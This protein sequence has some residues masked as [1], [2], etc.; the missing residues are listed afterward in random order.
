MKPG[1]GLDYSMVNEVRMNQT[2]WSRRAQRGGFTLVE[3]LVVIAILGILMVMMVPGAGLIMKRA[4][5]SQARSDA[6]IVGTVLLNY[7]S[8][9]NRWPEF[10]MGSADHLSDNTW[11]ECMSPTPGAPANA[12]NL[13]RVVFFQAGAGAIASGGANSGA[14]VDPWGTPFQ[15]KV[16]SDRDGQITHP[17]D[18]SITLRAQVLVWSAGEDGDFDTWDDNVTSWD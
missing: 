10:A 17:N 14:F 8:E 6:N 11:V 2:R 15:Y 9:Y 4:K 12:Q 18:D 7:F 13:K 5:R 1:G 16:D 3:L